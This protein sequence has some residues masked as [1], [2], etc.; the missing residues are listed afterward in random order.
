MI[1]VIKRTTTETTYEFSYIKSVNVK[2]EGLQMKQIQTFTM[3]Q[4]V[5]IVFHIGNNC[6]LI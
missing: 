2:C 1:T 5:F 4:S 6:D 3:V